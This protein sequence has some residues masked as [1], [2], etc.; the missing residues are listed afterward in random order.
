M[1]HDAR[2]TRQLRLQHALYVLTV[3]PARGQKESEGRP[4]RL[5]PA[6][7]PPR[8]RH[9]THLQAASYAKMKTARGDMAATAGG[10]GGMTGG[11]TTGAATYGAA[12]DGGGAAG[13]P[14]YAGAPEPTGM[15]VTVLLPGAMDGVE[16][17]PPIPPGM[18]GESTASNR[19][20]LAGGAITLA[21]SGMPP[22]DPGSVPA[23]RPSYAPAP[24]S[25]GMEPSSGIPPLGAAG[26]IPYR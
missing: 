20:R 11:G 22:Y 21:S 4:S 2:P 14:K 16:T 5:Q 24:G 6:Q 26:G 10:A 8:R 3:L 18:D 13:A 9:D 7:S 1:H 19:L 17:N 25:S 15:P 12:N 23:A